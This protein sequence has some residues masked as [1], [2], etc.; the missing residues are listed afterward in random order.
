MLNYQTEFLMEVHAQ[1][2]ANVSHV[3]RDNTRMARID[4]VNARHKAA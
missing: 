2:V 1:Y 3:N 4:V